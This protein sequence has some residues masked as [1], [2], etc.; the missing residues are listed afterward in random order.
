[1]CKSGSWL[2]VPQRVTA[3]DDTRTDNSA[4]QYGKYEGNSNFRAVA[5]DR[6]VRLHDVTI[7]VNSVWVNVEVLNIQ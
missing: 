2:V 4:E 3:E 6:Q 1:M 5:S 7:D